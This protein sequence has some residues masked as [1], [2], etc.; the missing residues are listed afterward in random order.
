M[1]PVKSGATATERRALI[2]TR[3]IL[4][5]ILW[6]QLGF[7]PVPGLL[8]SVESR[9][10]EVALSGT[11]AGQGFQASFQATLPDMGGSATAPVLGVP[12]AVTQTLESFSLNVNARL[13]EAECTSAVTVSGS[14]P[15]RVTAKGVSALGG[16]A[17]AVVVDCAGPI[18]AREELAVSGQFDAR[19]A[20]VPTGAA[21]A[22]TATV[23]AVT[24]I[25]R[26]RTLT[27][28]QTIA[29]G[30]SLTSGSELRTAGGSGAFLVFP[31]GSRLDLGENS[32]FVLED[33]D[34]AALRTRLVKGFARF[35]C[36]AASCPK[37]KTPLAAVAARGTVFL[38]EFRQAELLGRLTIGVQD[39]TVEL[40]SRVGARSFVTSGEQITIS[41]TVPRVNLILPADQGAVGEA[42]MNTFS[43][44]ALSGAAGYLLEF[45][46]SPTGFAQAN[47]S[48]V[49]FPANT[50]QVLPGAFR[51][52]EGVVEF[53][54]FVPAG[55]VP[56]GSQV[57]WRIFA[58]DAAGQIL[59]GTTASDS[60]T[61]FV[62]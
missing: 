55:A 11:V 31:D 42:V 23:E 19:S 43:W 57:H 10:W 37:V 52:S 29:P 62:E 40:I 13:A 47:S 35:V 14:A 16:F 9:T 15:I 39:G 32:S 54:I 5:A 8:P 20:A 60:A 4:A 33:P 38:V 36:Q 41:E 26:A 3:W 58:V 56:T 25:A 46:L 27:I 22:A 2:S 34:L 61:L 50:I 17:G 18:P 21:A 6:A 45:T 49:E 28:S 53:P 1:T 48:A 59:P 51:E 30:F 24:G 44:T 7:G 12:V